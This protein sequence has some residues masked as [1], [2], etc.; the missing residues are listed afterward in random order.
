MSVRGL[1]ARRLLMVRVGV[2][3]VVWIGE[4]VVGVKAV[5]VEAAVEVVAAGEVDEAVEDRGGVE[6][7]ISPSHPARNETHNTAMSIMLG[8]AL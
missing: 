3:V 4:D 1:G 7:V 5:V 2:V 6:R 8:S